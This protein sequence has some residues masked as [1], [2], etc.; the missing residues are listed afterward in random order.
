[1][2][3]GDTV[4]RRHGRAD[5]SGHS[6]RPRRR[7]AATRSAAASSTAAKLLPALRGKYIFTDITTGRIW[8]ADYKEMLAAD[9]GKPETMAAMHEMKMRWD[10]PNDAGDAGEAKSTTRCSRSPKRRTTPAAARSRHLPGRAPVSGEG[11][12]DAHVAVDAAGE[13][14]IFSK[15]DGTL[16]VVT[17]LD[18]GS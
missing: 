14:Y 2:Q 6:V 9:D 11:R 5:V 3:I 10:N 16:R 12:A 8:Y 1:M 18:A 13:L 4:D 15:T 17:A 7:A